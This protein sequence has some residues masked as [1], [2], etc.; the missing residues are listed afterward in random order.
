MKAVAH[1]G[2]TRADN[3]AESGAPIGGCDRA[4]RLL[5]GPGARGCRRAG[6]DEAGPCAGPRGH[7]G[8]TLGAG[9]EPERQTARESSPT[10]NA[11][12][13]ESRDPSDAAV[14]RDRHIG[15]DGQ[16]AVS[17]SR[18][19]AP[20]RHAPSGREYPG[21]ADRH[22]QHA[23]TCARH[24]RCGAF[25]SRPTPLGPA[26]RA[27]AGARHPDSCRSQ[28]FDRLPQRFR[29]SS[30]PGAGI[31]RHRRFLGH[32]GDPDR[33]PSP[34]HDHPAGARPLEVGLRWQALTPGRR[35]HARRAPRARGGHRRTRAPRV[36]RSR[37]HRRRDGEGRNRH[38]GRSR[39]RPSDHRQDQRGRC[40]RSSWRGWRGG[41][42][43]ADGEQG[44][45]RPQRNGRSLYP[46]EAAGRLG[47]LSL[48][49][50]R[51][52]TYMRAPRL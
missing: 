47:T 23:C 51:R 6:H 29:R 48:P 11:P 2:G 4:H 3:R 44:R 25:T 16:R 12:P 46:D 5:G 33:I 14:C 19:R 15:F 41:C 40:R 10:R 36:A 49:A 52:I 24:Q 35:G 26:E 42:R 31:G 38:G 8:F 34:A 45:G 27:H 39:G 21:W 32:A 7:P 22:P 50:V 13:S 28:R 17:P 20:A 43:S 30:N 37:P 9:G 1:P 18:L